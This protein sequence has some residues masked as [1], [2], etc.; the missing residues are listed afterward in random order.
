MKIIG[1]D[2]NTITL[3]QLAQLRPFEQPTITTEETRPMAN[4]PQIVVTRMRAL[5]YRGLA[6]IDVP[7]GPG[8]VI[9][10]GQNGEG[11][12][13]A[14]DLLPAALEGV[15]IGPECIR[16]G[17]DKTEILID[18]D[19]V[20]ENRRTKLEAKRTISKDG[21]KI[22]LTGGDGVPLPK[23]KEQLSALFGGRALDL[24]K[25]LMA[26]AKEQRAIVLAA[27]PVKVTGEDLTTWTGEAKD[28][29]TTGHGHEVLARVRQMYFDQR[30][31]AGQVADQAKA[32][33]QIKAGEADKLKVENPEAMT[34]DAARTHV[35]A[36]ERELAVLR[37]RRRQASERDAAAEGTRVRV[38]ELRAQAEELM[39]KPEATSPED[40]AIVK[41]DG[42]VSMLTTQ[43]Q[44]IEKTLAEARRQLDEKIK[45]R[46]AL[47]ARVTEASGIMADVERMIA[48]A[49]ELEQSIAPVAGS[50]PQDLAEQITAAEGSMESA[51]ALVTAAELTGKWRAAQAQVK[52]AELSEAIANT[53][54][55]RLN[56]IVETLTKVAPAEIASRADLIPG[57][58]L[59]EKAILLDGKDITVLCGAEKMRFAVSLAKRVAGMAKILRVDGM[60]ALAPKA[61]PEFV[62]M[63][64]E[65]GWM[66]FATVV[67]DGPMV[68]MDC[69]QFAGMAA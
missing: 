48:Q 4:D 19:K 17:A 15:G 25:F 44:E 30:T 26:N 69:Y 51:Q 54:W 52:E 33:A 62:R 34:P 31:K 58:E 2:G 9:F 27:H 56:K 35:A 10:I 29:N 13:T 1:P 63:C 32:A 3:E 46:D 22:A 60:E 8:G 16:L 18:M 55:E 53:E 43:V 68:V 40:T 47:H 61:Q 42:W 50:D 6:K 28:W 20:E 38:A 66:L 41:A 37:D 12:T 23:A 14:I 49:A 64:L 45:E 39:G 59:T 24:L 67:A 5:N 57:L 36:A 7:V 65:G 11:K 21:T